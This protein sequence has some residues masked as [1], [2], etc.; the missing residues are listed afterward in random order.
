MRWPV[1]IPLLSFLLINFSSRSQDFTGVWV[2]TLQTSGNELPYELVISQENDKYTGYSITTFTIEGVENTGVKSMKV[3]VK[4]DRVTIED[5]DLISDNYSTKSKRMMIYSTLVMTMQDTVHF[6]TGNFISRS[7]N[8]PGYKGTIVLK[9]QRHYEQTKVMARLA[10]LQLLNT[11]SFIKNPKRDQPVVLSSS[12]SIKNPQPTKG[13]QFAVPPVETLKTPV[14]NKVTVAP[15]AD[16]ARR[17][18]ETIRTLSYRSDSLVLTL[19]DNGQVD[20]DTVSVVVNGTTV[21]AKK[22]L[23]TT[24]INYTLHTNNFGDSIQVLM[25]AE[26]LGAIAPNTG[27]L[28]IQDGPV[29]HEVRFSGDLQRNSA[30]V[31]RREKR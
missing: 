21:L 26:N 19:F 5:D 16:I 10:Q 4:K 18:I 9:R 28:L 17:K 1:F 8:S 25:Y 12:T 13:N 15:A 24:A 14:E 6:L 23:N 27:L 31:L 11:I 3:K 20:G 7:Y 30:I 29:R 2:G 22:G